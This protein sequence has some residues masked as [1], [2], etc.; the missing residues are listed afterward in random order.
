M[1]QRQIRK[2]DHVA[3]RF[4]VLSGLALMMLLSGGFASSVA[5]GGDFVAE[6]ENYRLDNYL[7][8][9]PETL[10]GAIVIHAEA[11]HE[12]IAGGRELILIDVL[13]LPRKPPDLPADRLWR[14]PPRYHIAGSVW[15]PNVGLGDIPPDFK[16]Y[17][18]ENLARLTEND[19][20]R[21]LVF[22]CLEDCWMS[23]NAAK[24]ALE[25]DYTEVY[26]FP[27]GTNEWEFMD[28]ELVRGHPVKMPE[29]ENE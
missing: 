13:P 19:K 5:A 26:W 8:K 20:S 6:P 18:A 24:R 2:P 11:L 17:F 9:V 3:G 12:Q 23:W 21:A 10:R 7:A 25:F 22:Y 28:Y 4:G 15:L 29:F 1:M 16:R 27:G 14:T